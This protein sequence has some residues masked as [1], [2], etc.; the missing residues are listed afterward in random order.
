MTVRE[1]LNRIDSRELS[2]WVAYD[3]LEPIGSVRVDLAGAVVASTV[4]NC[5]RGKDQPAFTPMDF[6]LLQDRDVEDE[7]EQGA[8]LVGAKLQS[9]GLLSKGVTVKEVKE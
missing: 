3:T 8:S 6:M 9:F 1:L 4:A 5:H 7:V 2:E